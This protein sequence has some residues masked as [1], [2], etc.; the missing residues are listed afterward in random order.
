MKAMAKSGPTPLIDERAFIP[1]TVEET[2]AL[3][4]ALVSRAGASRGKAATIVMFLLHL[5]EVQRTESFYV[6]LSQY[7]PFLARLG[8][9]PWE[10]GPSRSKGAYNTSSDYSRGRGRGKARQGPRWDRPK[11]ESSVPGLIAA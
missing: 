4:N 7:R 1:S 2:R 3:S 10:R 8:E 11:N 9:P 6:R 5:D